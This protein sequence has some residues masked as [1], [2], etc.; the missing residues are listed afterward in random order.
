MHLMNISDL[1]FSP[2]WCNATASVGD[3]V[4]IASKPA[5]YLYSWSGEQLCEVS[6]QQLGVEGDIY[7]I[8]QAGEN[9]L[10]VI[11]GRGTS[12]INAIHLLD[13]VQ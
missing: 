12:S 8:G 11:T 7:G 5:L 1:P 3:T 4:I 13:I 6:R 10:H 9:Q 2:W